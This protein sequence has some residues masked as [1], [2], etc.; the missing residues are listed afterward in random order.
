[1]EYEQASIS[2]LC[3]FWRG[4]TLALTF[5]WVFVSNKQTNKQ[6]GILPSGPAFMYD[7]CTPFMIE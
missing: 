2:I 4:V 7:L 6:T 1:M 5:I 3:F